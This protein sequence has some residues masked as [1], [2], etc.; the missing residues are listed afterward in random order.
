MRQVCVGSCFPVDGMLSERGLKA[1]AREATS[2]AGG[3]LRTRL[4]ARW[5]V[6]EPL[7]LKTGIL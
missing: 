4:L 6:R 2:L 7:P 5:F 1:D 3:E